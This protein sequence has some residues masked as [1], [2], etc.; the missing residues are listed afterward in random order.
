MVCL[1][2]RKV[3]ILAIEW[4]N[5]KLNILPI[6]WEGPKKIL[7]QE[8]LC[9][10]I[11][12]IHEGRISESEMCPD[13]LEYATI[14]TQPTT[15]HH[16]NTNV[17]MQVSPECSCNI[18]QNNTECQYSA[19]NKPLVERVGLQEQFVEGV[20]KCG[21]VLSLLGQ[22]DVPVRSKKVKTT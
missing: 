13:M 18:I 14:T 11:V 9:Q 6:E 1:G 16:Q 20:T 10:C 19:I 7:Q 3:G 21:C 12:D 15:N 22:H 2:T 8:R 17:D 5:W 4:I